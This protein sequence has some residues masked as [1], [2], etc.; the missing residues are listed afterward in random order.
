MIGLMW[1]LMGMLTTGA[2][3]GYVN[4]NRQYHLSVVANL[5]LAAVFGLFWISIG[6]SWASFA[7]GESR[8]GA[9]GLVCFGLPALILLSLTWRHFIIPYP[10][11]S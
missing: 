1:Y 8:S 6:W 9:M 10:K 11:H 3:W 7:E 5:S 2:A 4:L